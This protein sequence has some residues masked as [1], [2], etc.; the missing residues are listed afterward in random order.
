MKPQQQSTFEPNNAL[1][2]LTMGGGVRIGRILEDMDIF[3]VHLVFK[4][5]DNPRQVLVSSAAKFPSLSTNLTLTLMLIRDLTLPP[6]CP[7][8]PPWWTPST[9]PDLSGTS[10]ASH[11]IRMTSEANFKFPS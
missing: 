2:Y 7:S 5:V 1:R 6:L 10:E 9:S 8:S 3:A 4:H 11:M